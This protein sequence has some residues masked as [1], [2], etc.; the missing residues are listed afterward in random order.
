MIK[1]AAGP[2]P[3]PPGLGNTF[4]FTYAAGLI[5]SLTLLPELMLDDSFQHAFPEVVWNILH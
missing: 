2:L 1:Y 3:N 4:A 5:M